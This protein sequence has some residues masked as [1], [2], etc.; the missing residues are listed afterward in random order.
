MDFSSLS[1]SECKVNLVNLP[2]DIFHFYLLIN[3]PLFFTLV[4]Y[5][6]S[7]LT[8][9][10]TTARFLMINYMLNIFCLL[11]PLFGCC[12]KLNRSV[13]LNMFLAL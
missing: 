7:V 3:Y 11:F 2:V 4:Y 9:A 13:S 5:P 8:T 10:E 1:S 12:D 6:Y